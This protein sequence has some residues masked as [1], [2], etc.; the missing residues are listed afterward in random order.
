MITSLAGESAS[1]LGL[2]AHP[3]QEPRC[4]PQARSRGVNFFFFYGPSPGRFGEAL[5]PLVRKRREEL[6]VASGSGSRKRGTLLAARR[7]I[8]DGLGI[9]MLDVFFAEYI[10]PNDDPAAIFGAGGVLDELDRWKA[11]GVIRYVGATAHDR[12]LAQQLAADPRVDVLMHR[13][14]M[15][16]RKAG[17]EVFPDAIRSKTPVIAFTATRWGTL[18]EP[19]AGWSGPPPS[20]VDC[21][22]YCL[23]HPAVQL[24]LTS[25][26]TSAELDENLA[27]LASPPL[28]DCERTHWEEF[29]DLVYGRGADAFD[30]QWQ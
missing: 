24:V 1:S 21:Y 2:A 26:K 23:V 27:V 9:E 8:L 29:G 30:T 25:P 11:G 18:L 4:V 16:H 28:T 20:A 10:N 15:A 6:L 22:R 19:R 14:N 13:F 3:E 5:A 7:K 17:Q 12:R